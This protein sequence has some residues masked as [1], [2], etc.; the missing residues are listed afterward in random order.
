MNIYFA[1][2]CSDDSTDSAASSTTAVTT[3]SSIR[4]GSEGNDQQG[5]STI[6]IGTSL[7]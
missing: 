7:N 4:S 3:A 2:V 1:I 6:L 5:N